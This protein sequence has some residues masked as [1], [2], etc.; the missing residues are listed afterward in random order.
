MA[1]SYLKEL[2]GALNEAAPAA[3][4]PPKCV[5]F[6]DKVHAPFKVWSA[7][8]RKTASHFFWP[9]S[10]LLPSSPP[11]GFFGFVRDVAP[12]QA[13]IVQVALGPMAQFLASLVP[14]P[15]GVEGV[16]Q[17]AQN[18]SNMMICHKFVVQSGHFQLRKLWLA[19]N[20][21]VFGAF[22]KRHFVPFRMK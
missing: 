18:T 15:P 1:G 13:D 5:R 10:M 6:G 9:R 4:G 14:S 16:A 8:G 17:L 20:I 21:C 11:E 12:G 2:A 3:H 22:R 19:A 7:A